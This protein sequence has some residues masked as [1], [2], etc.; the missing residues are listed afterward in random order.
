MGLDSEP[1]VYLRIQLQLFF[2]I[3]FVKTISETILCIFLT[4][5]WQ[6]FARGKGLK[7]DGKLKDKVG[8]KNTLLIPD[9]PEILSKLFVHYSLDYDL[10]I[11]IQVWFHIALNCFF[12][13]SFDGSETMTLER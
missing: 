13:S 11:W 8:F 4:W 6:K 2:Q 9:S 1:L 5:I 7:G 12:S 10:R 3:D